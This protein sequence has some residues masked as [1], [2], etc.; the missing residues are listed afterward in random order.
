MILSGVL[1]LPILLTNFRQCFKSVVEWAINCQMPDI[2]GCL[3]GQILSQVHNCEILF[4]MLPGNVFD[5]AR[6]GC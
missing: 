1:K 2:L 6:N 5:P 3:V 4:H